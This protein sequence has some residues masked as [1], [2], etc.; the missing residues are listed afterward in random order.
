MVNKLLMRA[1]NRLSP[2]IS[3]QVGPRALALPADSAQPDDE[4]VA[5]VAAWIDDLKLFATGWVGGLVFFGT[6]LG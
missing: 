6:L 5:A 4:D 1:M 2:L 3:R